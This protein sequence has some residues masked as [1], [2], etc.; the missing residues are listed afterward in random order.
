MKMKIPKEKSGI[1]FWRGRKDKKFLKNKMVDA[2]TRADADVISGF[3]GGSE[4]VSHH[5]NEGEVVRMKILV[6]KEDLDKVLQLVNANTSKSSEYSSISSSL[7]LEE[8]INSLKRERLS[9]ANLAKSRCRP[10][11]SWSPAL[12]SIPE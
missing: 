7:Y 1:K 3:G 12:H 10:N 9:R 5:K 8:C 6:K 2:N 4:V 11:S